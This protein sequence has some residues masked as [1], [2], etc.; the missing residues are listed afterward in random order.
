MAVHI[1]GSPLLAGALPPLYA[2]STESDYRMVFGVA[3]QYLQYYNRPDTAEDP[4]TSWALSQQVY[5]I[6]YT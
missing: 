5:I 1:L 6:S 2:N 3:L 4:N